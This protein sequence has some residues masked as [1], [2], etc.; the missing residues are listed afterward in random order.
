MKFK[1]S[2]EFKD[3]ADRKYLPEWEIEIDA[4]ILGDAYTEGLTLFR[5]HCEETG[6]DHE[7]FEVH[8]GTP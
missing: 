5:A 4:D 3:P 2:A 8:A 1:V 7:L 6:L